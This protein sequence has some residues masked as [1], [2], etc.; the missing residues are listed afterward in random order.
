MQGHVHHTATTIS[1][2]ACN[3][4]AQQTYSLQKS[5]SQT[6]GSRIS[7]THCTCHLEGQPVSHRRR[8]KTR[9]HKALHGY[10]VHQQCCILMQLSANR[11]GNTS[12]PWFDNTHALIL[13]SLSE[14]VTG[15]TTPPHQ[16]TTEHDGNSLTPSHNHFLKL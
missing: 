7:A 3:A 8:Y 11:R 16:G 9:N 14:I 10:H 4:L 2:D 13:T 1:Q 6:T 12:C 5:A 15:G